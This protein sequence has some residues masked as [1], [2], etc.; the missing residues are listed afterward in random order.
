[1]KADFLRSLVPGLMISGGIVFVS[2]TFLLGV[3][4]SYA[5]KAEQRANNLQLIVSQAAGDVV[6]SDTPPLGELLRDAAYLR[7]TFSDDN[8]LAIHEHVMQQ[9]AASR[10]EIQSIEPSRPTTKLPDEET[11]LGVRAYEIRC[12]AE[13]DAIVDFV[14]ELE[15][16]SPW[17][18][19]LDWSVEAFAQD[20]R[21]TVRGT[22]RF[23]QFSLDTTDMILLAQSLGEHE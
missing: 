11:T 20:G 3:A 6:S 16:R 2:Q 23:E 10:V 9:A 13:Y 18:R 7:K 5:H 4:E 8:P 21:P 14:L 1:M 19:S 15:R 12:V 22:L 17:M